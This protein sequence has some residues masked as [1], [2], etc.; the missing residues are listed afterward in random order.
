MVGGRT[1]HAAVVARQLGKACLVGCNSLEIDE[2]NRCIRLAGREL[3]EGDWLSI[4]GESGEISYGRAEVI[5]SGRKRNLPKAKRWSRGRADK[6][7]L[8]A[9]TGGAAP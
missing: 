5:L 6:L 7:N 9:A 8:I 3:R 2:N 1:S 4:G